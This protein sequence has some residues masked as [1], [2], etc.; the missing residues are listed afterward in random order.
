MATTRAKSAMVARMIGSILRRVRRA[1]LV[2]RPFPA[3]WVPIVEQ[4]LGF[5]AAWDADERARFRV[6]L[7]VFAWEKRFEGIGGLDVSEEM[8]VVVSGCA[9]RMSRNLALDVYDDLGSV[10]IAPGDLKRDDDGGRTL[11]MAHKWGTV[12][13]SWD[14]VRHGLATDNDGHDTTLHELAHILDAADGD[15]DGT[16]ILDRPADVRAWAAAFSRA[17]LAMKKSPDSGVLRAYGA[18]NE[19]EFFA[20]AT[21]VFFEKPRQLQKKLP[22]VY[23]ALSRVYRCDPAA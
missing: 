10:V 19:A 5:A 21:E 7:K 22:D 23:A 18:E 2:E 9:A 20:V 14:A 8:R 3:A 1:R 4:R 12:V 16:P 17:Y 11:G 15:F 6:H 13:L